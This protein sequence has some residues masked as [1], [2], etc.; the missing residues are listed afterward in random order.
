MHE[1]QKMF[2]PKQKS[3]KSIAM[4][5]RSMLVDM[6]WYYLQEVWYYTEEQTS[7]EGLRMSAPL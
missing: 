3:L 7:M 5:F 1:F 6:V 4:S 2:A